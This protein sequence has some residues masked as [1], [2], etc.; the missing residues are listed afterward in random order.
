MIVRHRAMSDRIRLVLLSFLMLFL[1]LALIR[2]AGSNVVH[3]SYFSNFVLLGS[4]LGIGIGF[5]SESSKRDLFRWAPAFLAVLVSFIWL[6]PVKID[7]SGSQLIYFGDFESTG[8]PVWVTLPVIFVAVALLLA[9][10]AQ[11]V[12]RVFIRLEPLDAYRFDILGS[13]LG[14]VV[15]A[16]LSFAYAPPIV[17]G[18]VV[19]V[20]FLVLLGRRLPLLGAGGLVAV[21]VILAL[22]SMQSGTI[23]SPYYKL[24]YEPIP[25]TAGETTV[26]VSANGLPHQFITSVRA[27]REFEGLYF[28]PYEWAPSLPLDDVLIVGA[29]NGTDVAVA[30]S[31]GAK[32]VDAVEIDPRLYE[33]GAEMHP[34]RPYQDPA[35]E[36]YVDDGR[37][38]LE[39]TSRSYDL[40]MFALPD[41]LTLVSG[42]ASLRLESYLFTAQA[43]DAARDHL[44]PHG[45]FAMYNYYREPWLI[46]RL[47]RGLTESYGEPPCVETVGRVGGLAVML[48]SQDPTAVDCPT[49]WQPTTV[50]LEQPSDDWPFVY[51][52]R[53]GIP[54]IYLWT[55]GLILAASALLVRSVAGP[56]SRMRNYVD[57]FFMGVAFL[58]LE[59]KNV[60][61]FALLFGTTWFVNALVFAGILLTVYVAIEVSRK[62]TVRR[63]GFLYLALLVALAVA[64]LVPGETLLRLDAGPRF[65]AATLLAFSPIF[66]ANLVF[67]QRFKD[68]GSST[69][70]FGAN[71]LG[72]MLGG[73]L[74]YSALLVGYNA[75]LIVTGVLYGLAFV[76]GRRQFQAAGEA[77][78]LA[79]TASHPSTAG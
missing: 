23:W 58:L 70:A 61:Q 3:L 53:R 28:T 7:R 36:V 40:I 79:T 54:A 63:P 48:N 24:E 64:Y 15:F 55:I 32:H 43:M 47:A 33:L 72:A 44:K 17:W 5:L 29:G 71:L 6:F 68:V 20:M 74:E 37:A 38:F 57:L 4:F 73:V 19:S 49:R 16:A 8:L 26:T 67:A 39:E 45:V 34:N 50:S 69:I 30:L 62:V 11:G 1:E 35:V 2:W 41:S 9:T 51:L 12:A 65:A 76:F 10:V 56:F 14:I 75:L 59:T 21:L 52:Q 66:L 42:Q 25:N 46:D 27:R 31:Q 77:R 13:I 78:G 60:V 22:E 18:L